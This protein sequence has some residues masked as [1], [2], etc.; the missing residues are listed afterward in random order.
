MKICPNRIVCI[1]IAIGCICL[2]IFDVALLIAYKG[3]AIPAV[4]VMSILF[5]AILLRYASAAGKVLTLDC[6]G[7]TISFLLYRKRYL[8]SEF[9]VKR[10][11]DFQNTHSYRQQPEE[12]A[13]FSIKSFRRPRWMGP[14]EF[15]MLTAP[16][17][18]FFVCFRVGDAR[19]P[20]PYT[21]DKT[22]F[23]N[24]LARWGVVLDE[25]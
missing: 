16:L 19:Y 13:I 7:C 5:L 14:L 20:N 15:F 17:S 21:V 23:L 3:A 9:S 8:W 4:V 2:C 24:A 22:D 11:E 10:L 18:S 1:S 25:G 6:E 12:G